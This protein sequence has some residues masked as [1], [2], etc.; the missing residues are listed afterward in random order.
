MRIAIAELELE[1]ALIREGSKR[2]RREEIVRRLDHRRA[3]IE[4]RSDDEYYK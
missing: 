1:A 3:G 2:M 4:S